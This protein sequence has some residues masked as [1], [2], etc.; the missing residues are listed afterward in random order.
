MEEPRK[1]DRASADDES[2]ADSETPEIKKR[3]HV[4]NPNNP[5]WQTTSDQSKTFLTRGGRRSMPPNRL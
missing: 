2:G 1:S 3:K 4:K 5:R